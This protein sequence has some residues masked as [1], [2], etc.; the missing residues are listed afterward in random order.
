MGLARR[1]VCCG[2]W[3]ASAIAPA[4]AADAEPTRPAL[5]MNRWQ[6]DWSVLSD[7]ALRT[8]ALDGLKYLPL[9]N[10]SAERY[11]SLGL[12]LRERFEYN[13][14]SG[15]GVSGPG[16]DS[17]VL[18]RLQV[19]ADLHFADRW[20]LFTQLEDARAFSKKT[21]TPVD[22]NKADLRL[23][24]L[25]TVQAFASGT[26]KARIGRQDFAFDL[27]RFVSSRDGPNVRQSFDAVWADW[28]TE[29]WR[30]NGF[31][32]RPVQYEDVHAFDDRSDN[33]LRF[34][35]LRVER[36]ILGRNELSAY[37][38]LY[39]RGAA[40]YL[41]GGGFEHRQILDLRCAGK[42]G[43]VDWDLETM[44]QGG[45]V[46]DK[47][48]RAWAIGPSA[49]Y[50]FLSLPWRPRAGLQVD[51]ASGDTKSGDRT[52]GTFN[53]LFP[54][55]YYFS[56]AGYTGYA[57][58]VQAKP[59]LTVHPDAR[60]SLLAGLG[61]QWRATTADAVYVQPN[62]PVPGTAGRPGRWT[63]AYGQLR[64]DYK[65]NANLT[66]AIEAVHFA[67][68]DTVRRAGGH[69]SDYVGVEGKFMW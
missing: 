53:P 54:N 50:T 8:Q 37:W 64:A 9:S 4:V 17:Y 11:L 26:L 23:A 44:F 65:A 60:L 35:T 51:A 34:H 6:E 5:M 19:H 59:T 24:F 42:Q 55:G 28:E 45:K 57:N 56:L 58:L 31:L 49:G 25:E 13:D 52:V 39:E 38:A 10:D 40:H 22:E 20:R 36:H 2:L 47:K 14:A 33:S 43:D 7:P 15:F 16:S 62:V 32:S 21:L 29:L 30:F 18:Q 41:D 66:A 12:T 27:Q 63:G 69:D 46:G 67:V 3:A 61:L 1:V 48:I 68:G